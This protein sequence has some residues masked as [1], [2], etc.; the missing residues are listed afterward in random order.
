MTSSPASPLVRL[1]DALIRLRLPIFVGSLVMTA[2]AVLPA[3]QLAFDQTVESMFS[4]DDP[5][6]VD[7][8]HSKR[9][10]GGD[11]LVGVIYRDPK[12]FSDEGL[13]RVKG[14]AGE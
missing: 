9:F 2:L 3:R 11:E 6:L 12:L 4:D 7:Y 8:V 1:V 14:L 10:F 5:H 13:S